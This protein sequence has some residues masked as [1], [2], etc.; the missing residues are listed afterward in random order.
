MAR[1]IRRPVR[2]RSRPS[3][4]IAAPADK[5]RRSSIW[6]KRIRI[7]SVRGA[8][9]ARQRLV[10]TRRASTLV[11]DYLTEAGLGVR[12]F[13]DGDYPAI[14]ATLAAG[15]RPPVL[16]SAHLDV[17]DPDP[18]EGQFE[19]RLEGDYLHGRG[20]ADMKTVL[21]PSCLAQRPRAVA[22]SPVGLS[23]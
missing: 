14:F 1:A 16:L 21:P 12:I 23:W 8:S 19:P 4:I 6:R 20:A 5:R 3:T 22:R 15:A 13:E 18:D 9:P 17:V 11:Y 7:R 2:F 10:E